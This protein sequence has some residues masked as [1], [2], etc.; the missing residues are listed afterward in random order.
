MA[1]RG[2][3]DV[4]GG[5]GGYDGDNIFFG[6]LVGG[7]FGV[8]VFWSDSAWGFSDQNVI[9]YNNTLLILEKEI[10]LSAFDK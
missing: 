5:G 9:Q 7:F 1:G 3:R 8:V 10:E 2:S 6:C 4:G